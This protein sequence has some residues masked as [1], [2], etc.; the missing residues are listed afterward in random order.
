MDKA[1][2][3]IHGD[4]VAALH[5]KGVLFLDARRTSVYEQGHIAGARPFSVWR[6]TDCA[7]ALRSES[8][9]LLRP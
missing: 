1:Y 8:S 4:D 2:I 7:S 9:V 6:V 5:A 3:E